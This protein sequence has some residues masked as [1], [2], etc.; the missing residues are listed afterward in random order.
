MLLGPLGEFAP[1][2]RHLDQKLLAALARHILG[3]QKAFPRSPPILIRFIHAGVHAALP[4]KHSAAESVPNMAPVTGFF[5]GRACEPSPGRPRPGDAAQKYGRAVHVR[6]RPQPNGGC[7]SRLM[8][9]GAMPARGQEM[10]P[11]STGFPQFFGKLIAGEIHW[12]G[13]EVSPNLARLRCACQST[14]AGGHGNDSQPP[15]DR[16]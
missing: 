13:S 16:R 11:G 15:V 6:G 1:A 12:R 14:P 10:F 2:K 5:F 3:E 4:G 7:K 8:D 9:R